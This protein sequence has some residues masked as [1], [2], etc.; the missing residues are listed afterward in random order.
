VVGSSPLELAEGSTA[1]VVSPVPP[2]LGSPVVEGSAVVELVGVDVVVGSAVVPLAD[3]SES[4][5]ADEGP[6]VGPDVGSEEPAEGS[7]VPESPESWFGVTSTAPGP[8]PNTINNPMPAASL[9]MR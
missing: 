2:L 3:A 5:P 7:L 1:P 4:E 9:P 6:P 8:Q